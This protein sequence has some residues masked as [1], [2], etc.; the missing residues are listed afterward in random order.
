MAAPQHIIYLEPAAPPK[1]ALG[2]ACNGCGL[3]CLAEP[4]PLGILLSGRRYGAC[5]ALRWEAASSQYRCG[6]LSA[7]QSVVQQAL[8]KALQWLTPAL[9]WCL[10]HWA[11][12]WIAQGVGCD[13]TMQAQPLADSPTDLPPPPHD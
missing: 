12:R 13:S 1:P 5:D 8:P 10:G 3:C 4:C 9:A 7:P 11:G 2:A 6:A